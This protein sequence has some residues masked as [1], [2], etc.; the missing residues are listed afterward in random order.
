MLKYSVSEF[1]FMITTK[2]RQYFNNYSQRECNR[3]GK[4]V[5]AIKVTS[6]NIH[7][8]SVEHAKCLP[9]AISICRVYSVLMYLPEAISASRAGDY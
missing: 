2:S 9:V 4:G 1:F 6:R 5:G 8:E 3:R 7:P